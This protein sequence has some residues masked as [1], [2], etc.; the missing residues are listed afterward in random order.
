MKRSI[1][2]LAIAALAPLALAQPQAARPQPDDPAARA[3]AAPYESAFAGYVPY[4]EEKL[5]PWRDVNDEVGR[6]GGHVG[7]FRGAGGQNAAQ[8]GPSTPPAG[9]P[10]ARGAQQAPQSGHQGH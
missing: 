9:E 8:P 3:P 2:F 6:I 5:A 4:R 1:A 10:P 7:L